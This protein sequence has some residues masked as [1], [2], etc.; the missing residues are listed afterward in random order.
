MNRSRSAVLVLLTALLCGV[1]GVVGSTLGV[2]WGG[3][4]LGWMLAWSAALAVDHV[5]PRHGP[6]APVLAALL[7]GGALGS[8]FLPA[9]LQGEVP[10]LL[11]LAAVARAQGRWPLLVAWLGLIPALSVAPLLQARRLGA[12]PTGQLLAGGLGGLVLAIALAPGTTAQAGL[13]YLIV[14]CLAAG[15]ALGGAAW[16][17]QTGGPAPTRLPPAVLA[18]LAAV[19]L[20]L[21]GATG[22]LARWKLAEPSELAREGQVID[23]LRA[24]YAAQERLRARS[25]AY[26]QHPGQLD[27]VD[28]A[29]LGGYGQGYLYRFWCDPTR[30]AVAADPAGPLDTVHFMIDGRGQVERGTRPF[31]IGGE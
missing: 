17:G 16:A 3:L 9:A 21:G 29:I 20:L 25:G 19:I 27:G 7:A 26:A 4:L 15:T 6:A 23:A 5:A 11:G 22:A 8:A 18:S 24:I 12:G 31:A 30:W 13:G 28:R 10:P 2:A 14:S 1:P